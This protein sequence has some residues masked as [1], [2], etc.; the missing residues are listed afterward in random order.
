M[1]NIMINLI[2][3]IGLSLLGMGISTAAPSSDCD[4]DVQPIN[5]QSATQNISIKS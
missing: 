4:D 3:I 2:A 1:K 5:V